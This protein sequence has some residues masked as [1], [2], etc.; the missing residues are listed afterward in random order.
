L[1]P[2]RILVADMPRL[3]REIVTELLRGQPDVE[4]IA[5][6]ARADMAPE[7]AARSRAQV[8]IL[9]RDDPRAARLLLE[10]MPRLLVLT[11]A[12]QELVAWSYGLTPYREC[13]GELSAPALSTAIHARA[14]LCPW[15]T[16]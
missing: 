13:L 12:D 8:V 3:Q 4:V 9:G 16:E 2:T 10:A 11:V 5:S 1:P 7:E 15:W 14:G 6:G